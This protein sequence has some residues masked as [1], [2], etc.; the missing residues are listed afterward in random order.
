MG[1]LFVVVAGTGTGGCGSD[2]DTKDGLHS[3]SVTRLE[4]TRQRGNGARGG[5]SGL[6]L[7]LEGKDFG[8]AE[9]ALRLSAWHIPRR[10]LLPTLHFGLAEVV[11]V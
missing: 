10:G 1:C 3:S 11:A 5:A 7:G 9:L 4:M 8:G 2:S 6:R